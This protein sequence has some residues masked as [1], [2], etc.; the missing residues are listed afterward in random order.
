MAQNCFLHESQ[1]IGVY[2]T[3]SHL[4]REHRGVLDFAAASAPSMTA[5]DLLK[6]ASMASFGSSSGLIEIGVWHKGQGGA[7]RSSDT[8]FSQ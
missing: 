1:V 8:Y 5:Q 2:S 6:C 4:F 3:F 7:I